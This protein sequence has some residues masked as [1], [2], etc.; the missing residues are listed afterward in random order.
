[1]IGSLKYRLPGKAPVVQEG[2]FV[3]IASLNDF[4]GFVVSDFDQ[5]SLYGFKAGYSSDSV[6]EFEAPFSYNHDDY[7]AKIDRCIR[8][9]Q[10]GNL[11]KVIFSRIKKVSITSSSVFDDLCRAYPNAFVY[12]LKSNV[13]GH[14]TGATPE[15]LLD[16]KGTMQTLIALAG[17]KLANDDSQWG[18][19]EKEEQHYVESFIEEVIG[20]QG[21]AL[22]AKIGPIDKIAGPVKHLCTTYE[23]DGKIEL[24]S[25]VSMLHPTPAVS[26]VPQEKA[27]DLIQKIEQHN[28]QLYT[29]V[30]GLVAND[31]ADL[32][33]NLRCMQVI[34]NTA[35][36]YVGGGITIDS[37][38]ELEWV[39]T[40]NKAITLQSI[41]KNS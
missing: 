21:L 6:R 22:K 41:L 4:N 12:E 11:E 17:T 31:S 20:R 28:R 7:I 37:D 8:E 26:G 30:L 13:L 36:L 27:I 23:C 33:V 19:K 38:P 5:S 24:H 39:E 10:L 18:E 32:F 35:Y 16:K 14:W 40:E 25:L 34:D 15:L 2:D 1:M 29:G 3:A 9:I